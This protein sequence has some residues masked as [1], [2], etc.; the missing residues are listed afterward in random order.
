ML[1]GNSVNDHQEDRYFLKKIKNFKNFSAEIEEIDRKYIVF[2]HRV[3]DHLT[4]YITNFFIGREE[5]SI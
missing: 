1:S 5:E 4:I 3:C 2:T